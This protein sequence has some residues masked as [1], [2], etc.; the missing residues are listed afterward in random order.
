MPLTGLN[1]YLL[2]ARNLE[3]T[4]DFF[5]GEIVDPAKWSGE[6][7]ASAVTLDGSG[8]KRTRVRKQN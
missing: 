6:G 5:L 1:H 8:G 4:K 7:S 3:Q 2:V